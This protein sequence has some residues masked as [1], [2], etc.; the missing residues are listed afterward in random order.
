MPVTD[1]YLQVQGEIKAGLARYERHFEQRQ[2]QEAI[3][4]LRIEGLSAA[5]EAR[6]ARLDDFTDESLELSMPQYLRDSA[7]FQSA[8]VRCR[9][10]FRALQGIEL[11]LGR[12]DLEWKVAFGRLDGHAERIVQLWEEVGR[13]PAGKGT[14]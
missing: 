1:G 13:P 3:L 12:I 14:I 10:T 2:E 8:L 4:N 6:K 9:S 7:E 11:E 5:A